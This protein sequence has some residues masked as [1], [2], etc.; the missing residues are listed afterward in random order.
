[1]NKSIKTVENLHFI[2][3]FLE[4]IVLI[5]IRE[6]SFPAQSGFIDFL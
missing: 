2:G 6:A 4:I 5:I 3:L 1:M